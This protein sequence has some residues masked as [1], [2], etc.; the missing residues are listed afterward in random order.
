M[1]AGHPRS[2][3]AAALAVASATAG[4][5]AQDLS[6]PG[7]RTPAQRDVTVVRANGSTFTA[8]VHYPATAAQAGSPVDA[9][10][11]PYPIIAFGHGFVTPISNYASTAAHLASWGF[12][13]MLPQTQGSLFPS[14]A[15]FAA[16]FVS[17]LDWMGAQG[18]V[19]GSAWAGAVDA[20]RRGAMG[21]SMGG[22]AALLAADADPSIRAVVPMAAAETNPSS[23]A[24]CNGIAVATRIINGSQ[25]T[26]VAPST[27]GP[28]YA[29]LRGPSQLV[30][31]TGGSHCGFIDSAIAFCDSG[32]ITRAAQ[33][34]IVRREVT[35]FMLLLP[36]RRRVALGRRVGRARARRGRRA[37]GA[38]DAGPRRQRAHRGGGPRHHA[39]QLGRR[40]PR[41]PRRRR[42]DHRLGP[43]AAARGVDRMSE[44]GPA[45]ARGTAGGA[46]AVFLVLCIGGGAASGLATPPGE[47]Y[48]SIAKPSWTPPGW[49]FGPVW[50]ALYAM[51]GVAAWLL[52][53]RRAD[54]TAR[55][56]LACFAVQL[57]LNF[58]WTPAFFG[59]RSPGLAL[60]IIVALLGAIA[61]T[62]VASWRA[63]RAAAWLLVP[64]L[65]WVG[66]ATALNAAIWRLN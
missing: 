47:W 21:H 18:G 11:G 61:A 26:I 50:T 51:M 7:P 17:A 48:A 19:A 9:A 42:L 60:A 36:A 12:I 8:T 52:W 20:S 58:A 54:R 35:E 64:Y 4:V 45:A 49:L 59:L 24:A 1:Q 2:L 46:L 38:A 15:A 55:R 22:G 62:V 56:A 65:A 34:A 43:R 29:N 23:T 33:L 30:T 32:S 53:R 10:N 6:Q 57:A 16:D 3:A 13:V 27:N 44:P 66:F 28:M 63:S 40:R 25:D 14:H 31:I 41:R 5:T 39:V 37:A